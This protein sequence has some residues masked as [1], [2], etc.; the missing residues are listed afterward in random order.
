MN[1]RQ[2][3]IKVCYCKIPL[4]KEMERLD[5]LQY[6]EDFLLELVFNYSNRKYVV[7]SQCSLCPKTVDF[8]SKPGNH[9]YLGA[10]LCFLN[11]ILL[12]I[13]QTYVYKNYGNLRSI[14]ESY[15]IQNINYIFYE[16][17]LLTLLWKLPQR[18]M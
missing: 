11:Y 5:G 4:S 17:P 6:L 8:Y 13:S 18:L 14:L 2:I 10:F 16:Y 7:I 12:L 15:L 9:A 3:D 1:E